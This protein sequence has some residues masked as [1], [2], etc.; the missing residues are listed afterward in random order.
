[1]LAATH[2]P[3]GGSARR[4]RQSAGKL[5]PVIAKRAFEAKFFNTVASR[6]LHRSV[7]LNDTVTVLLSQDSSVLTTSVTVPTFGSALFVLSAFAQSSGFLTVFDQYKFLQ[8]EC[9]LEPISVQ[10]SITDNALFSCIDLD[11]ANAPSSTAQVASRPTSL[12]GGGSAGRYYCFV[13]HMATAV[14]S[15]AFTS[16]GNE[17]P[18]WIDVA[19]PSV[20]HYGLKFASNPTTSPITYRLTT[21]AVVSFRGAAT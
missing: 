12:V 15:G 2:T 16:F 1:M 10:G 9:W 11:D 13:P 17:E 5:K 21:Q 6:P 7:P 4:S 3:P 20:Q 8:I 14:Y 18:Q 19:S